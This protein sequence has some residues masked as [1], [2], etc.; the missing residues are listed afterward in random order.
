MLLHFIDESS[1]Q[2]CNSFLILELENFLSFTTGAAC[3]AGFQPI[4]AKFDT[5]GEIFGYACSKSLHLPSEVPF[6]DDFKQAMQV[7][8]TSDGGPSFNT[9]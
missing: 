4:A 7:A 1:E 3:V 5:D 6:Y 2:G 9:P 8:I